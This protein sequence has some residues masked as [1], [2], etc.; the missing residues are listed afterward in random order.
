MA[1]A[2]DRR[3][4]QDLADDISV[5]G[6]ADRHRHPNLAEMAPVLGDFSS[7][8]RVL[9]SIGAGGM[10]TV[11]SAFDERLGVTVALKTLNELNADQLYHLKSEFRA[12]A[13]VRHPNLVRLYELFVTDGGC[14]FTMELVQ[15]TDLVTY[16]RGEGSH[17]GSSMILAGAQLASAIHAVHLARRL[18]CD[19]KPSN[20]LVDRTGKVVLLDFGLS[21]PFRHD[22]DR[23]VATSQ[24]A[25][26][27]GYMAP[28]QAYGA[29]LDASADWYAFGATLFEA[30]TGSLPFEPRHS[31]W[32]TTTRGSRR[33]IRDLVPAF[34]REMDE[35]VARLLDAE[36][37]ERPKGEEVVD[38]LAGA[39]TAKA[40]RVPNLSTRHFVGRSRELKLL[41]GA[42]EAVRGGRMVTAYLHGASGIG[43]SE[44]ARR[45][46][47]SAMQSGCTVL[48]GKCHPLETVPYNAL[49]G[50]IDELS[51]YLQ[52]EQS[53]DFQASSFEHWLN[54]ARMFPVL[55]RANDS[56][57]DAMRVSV[58]ANDADIPTRGARSLRELFRSLATS[59]PLVVWLDDLQWADEDSSRV[60]RELV[61]GPDVPPFL[62]LVSYRAEG[63]HSS[64]V[65]PLHDELTLEASNV[66][67][68]GLHPLSPDDT[69]ALVERI[70][71]VQS[72]EGA[73]STTRL[74]EQAQGVPFFVQEV[75]WALASSA[76]QEVT[77][78]MGQERLLTR[79][80]QSLDEARRRI[81]EVICVAGGPLEPEFV[82]RAA[83]LSA[84]AR[85]SLYDLE[86]DHFVRS[87]QAST[88]PSVEI[89]HDCLRDSVLA[90]LDDRTRRQHHS[91]IAAA[92]VNGARTNYPRVVEHLDAA[93]DVEGV[94]RL[95]VAAAR[96]AEAVFAFD[97][98]ARWYS[99][100][101]E[102][103]GTGLDEMELRECLGAALAGAGRG[104]EAGRVFEDA[105]ELAERTGQMPERSLRLR[106]EAAEQYLKS[107]Q[108]GDATRA[109]DAVVEPLGIRMPKSRGA[110][111]AATLVNRAYIWWHGLEPKAPGARDTNAADRLGVLLLL[112]Q[113]YAMTEHTYGFA[114]GSR[115]LREGLACDDA[116]LLM[117]G[118]A[119]ESCSWAALAGTTS[120]RTADGH[121]AAMD[122]VA[123][124]QPSP[125]RIASLQQCRGVAGF[126]RGQFAH[127]VSELELA[128]A[129][130]QRR[131]SGATVLSA[132]N[133]AFRLASLSFL[134]RL[135]EQARLLDGALADAQA[136]GDDYLIATCA[137][138]N[139]TLGWLWT[140][141]SQEC[142]KWAE[143]VLSL[144]PPGFS[145][146]HFQYLLTSVNAALL[147]GRA[148]DAWHQVE[149]SWAA[150]QSNHFLA[151][152]CIGEDLRQTR[153]RA[154]LAAATQNVGGTRDGLLRAS[155]AE[156][157]QLDKSR[158]PSASAWASL[159]RAG[160]AS[161]RGD[162]P[163]AIACLQHGIPQLV[164][165]DLA[166]HALAAR[167]VMAELQGATDQQAD[168][169]RELLALGVVAPHAVS[170]ALVPGVA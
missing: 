84:A 128:A 81:V 156:A 19:I 11:Y 10:G 87:T 145:S 89:Y 150:V 17:D 20:V 137:A 51:Q 74:I 78:P 155:L 48:R 125:Y 42:L 102:L 157:R 126:F 165:T 18:H 116:D 135:Q 6:E 73:S 134:G 149:T 35:F 159:I 127:A 57:G 121:L 69:M 103:G 28:E 153:A 46:V 34:P 85:V 67:D 33:R 8:F 86:D 9:A 25:G 167:Y 152:S 117:N 63:F 54:A 3:D 123:V 90:M 83:G 58:D 104:P 27:A 47:D 146:Q 1:N 49:D 77:P 75:A 61:R 92:I 144:A 114:F 158:L 168:A 130:W 70:A 14:F 31:L 110:A 119:A 141:R 53:K 101:L 170:R 106:K 64:Q 4:V 107:W 43:K 164:A 36:P 124:S 55:A 97:S 105:A 72:S 161:M 52:H 80:V 71:G 96:Q 95:A 99:R 151:L 39:N 142:L 59:R 5:D 79:R 98:S 169:E 30:A 37:T 139:Q 154:A 131:S 160:V 38:F 108:R 147:H 91:A 132:A 66:V 136:R 129:A 40:L 26:T 23:T 7:R 2:E 166:L 113:V 88:S 56:I 45:F 120:Q 68:I 100:A 44:L 148:M 21:V 22:E 162:R 140:S 12:L 62:L 93:G 94:R 133:F 112:M 111:I 65:R 24:F 15:G 13:N 122:R 76:D 143:R 16:A 29:A 163:R 118:L 60:L 50:M 82:L 115:L 138:G 41:E 32:R 109:L